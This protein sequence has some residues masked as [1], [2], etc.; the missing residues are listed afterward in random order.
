MKTARTT[1]N[2]K[3]ALLVRLRWFAR[4]HKRTL[5]NVIEEGVTEVLS[6]NEEERR[7]AMYNGLERL[8]K[9]IAKTCQPDPKYAG[10]SVDEI[11]YGED[12]AWR[13]SYRE[14]DGR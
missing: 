14:D 8:R 5:S 11:L 12:G 2:M 3:P 4:Y 13:G 9:Q 10:K 7:A 6:K 1:I